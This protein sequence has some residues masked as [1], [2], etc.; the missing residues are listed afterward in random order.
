[1]EVLV[2]EGLAMEIE[3]GAVE[4]ARGAGRILQSRFGGPL[5]VEYKDE[6]KE[7]DP[8]T[9][10][11]KESQAYLSEY[12]ASHF[13]DH[14]ILGE[15]GSR[16]DES[17]APEFLWILDPLDGTTNF[18]NG[19]PIYAV[20]IGVL[21][22]GSPV[23]GA[24]FIPWPGEK[25]GVVLHARKGGG[26]WMDEEP[27]SIPGSETIRANR[28]TG[29]PASFGGRF[30]LGKDLRRQVGEVRVTGSVAYELALTALGSFQYA[31]FGG[32]RI[33]D[34]AG[35]TI[36]VMEAGGMVMARD[37]KDRGWEPLTVLGP[38]WGKGPPTMKEV[39]NWSASL[40]VGN[41]HIA[42]FVGANL[43]GRYPLSA[44]VARLIRR[45]KR[46]LR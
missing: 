18:L 31:V 26:A 27:V 28:L 21:H 36:I 1:M 3:A 43:R 16:E 29:L 35:G 46:K 13:P 22:R 44:R 20:S 24:L 25:D 15:E 17:P 9:S 41:A 14:G 42:P 39:R 38:S 30:R 45:L 40:I 2:D 4:M 19:L 5:E 34:M 6:K 37:R 32:P 11:D 12:I 33:W 23:A 7:Q 10:A 8:V